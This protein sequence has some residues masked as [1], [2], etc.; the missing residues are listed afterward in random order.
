MIDA[1]SDGPNA[2]EDE[3]HIYLPAG[4]LA[5]TY[6]RDREVIDGLARQIRERAA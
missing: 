3:G 4:W 2:I 6:P 1:M 5:R